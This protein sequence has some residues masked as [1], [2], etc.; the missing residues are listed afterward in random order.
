MDELH[1]GYALVG[2]LAVVFA[3][4]STNVRDLPFS[5]PLLVTAE[6]QIPGIAI[7]GHGVLALRLLVCTLLIAIGIW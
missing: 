7:A 2:S 1:L 5:E 6:R 3:A 4:M